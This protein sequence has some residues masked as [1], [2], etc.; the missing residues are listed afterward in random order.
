[1]FNLTKKHTPMT[2]ANCYLSSQIS[3]E[4]IELDA[5]K[6]LNLRAREVC[7]RIFNYTDIPEFFN[8]EDK[9]SMSFTKGP[10]L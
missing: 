9:S 7:A 1:M 8:N 6:R 3:C 4:N 10:K 5:T 2:V